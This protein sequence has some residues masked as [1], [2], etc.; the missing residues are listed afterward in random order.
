MGI[1]MVCYC[2]IE[3][4]VVNEVEIIEGIFVDVEV[5][6]VLIFIIED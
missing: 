1:G 5:M 3:L 2:N 4:F 6:E